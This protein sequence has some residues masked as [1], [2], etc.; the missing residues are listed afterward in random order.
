L[1]LILLA[2]LL[3]GLAR[4]LFA[5]MGLVSVRLILFGCISNNQRDKLRH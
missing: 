1:V 2:L 3:P 4:G 5:A